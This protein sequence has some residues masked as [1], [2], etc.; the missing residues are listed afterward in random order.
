LFVEY[1]GD[2]PAIGN[3]NGS[4]EGRKLTERVA[5]MVNAGAGGSWNM[6]NQRTIKA[7]SIVE[8]IRSGMSTH[9][10]M[11]KYGLSAKGLG[12]AFKQLVKANAVSREELFR[13]RSLPSGE[14]GVDTIRELTRY[15]IDFDL[16]LFEEGNP[17]AQGSVRDITPEGIG[18]AGIEARVDEIKRLVILGDEFGQV[19]PF[20]VKAVCRWAKR[21]G[22][23]GVCM[24]G[25]QITSVTDED[26]EE[27]L[28]LIRLV[29]FNA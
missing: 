19:D 8:D 13:D 2:E 18:V 7:K 5:P 16:P 20:K 29:T 27:L 6:P 1:Y 14:A 4:P 25:F 3:P 28:K 11:R 12:S 26:Y 21:N 24:S 9:A 10:L 17:E 22:A 23:A 15:Y